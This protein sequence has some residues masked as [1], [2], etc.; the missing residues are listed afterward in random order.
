[1]LDLAIWI[2]IIGLIATVISLMIGIISLWYNLK[3]SYKSQEY[4]KQI[5]K[6][7]SK[8]ISILKKQVKR[9]EKGHPKNEQ[10]EREKLELKRKEQENK[11]KWKQVDA[12]FKT[13]KF[14]RDLKD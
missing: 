9:L 7:Q 11:E 2:A 8:Q 6:N 14:F 12:I 5:T 1:M 4:L 13:I 10:L 3:Q